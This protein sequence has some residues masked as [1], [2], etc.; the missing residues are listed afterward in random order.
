MELETDENGNVSF[1]PVLTWGV[2]M[3]QGR[4]VGVAADYYASAEDAAARKVTRIQLHL[5]PG[6][7]AELGRA[8][9]THAE[10]LR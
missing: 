8:L 4:T 1:L 10:K 6:P 2:W 7:A 3:V 5:D 9:I